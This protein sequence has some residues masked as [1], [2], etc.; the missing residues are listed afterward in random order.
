LV[1]EAGG[2]IGNFNGDGDY[3]HNGAV[4]AGSPKIFA[5]TVALLS[6]FAGAPSAK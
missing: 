1:S 5:Q 3:L 2:I 4:I 6:P